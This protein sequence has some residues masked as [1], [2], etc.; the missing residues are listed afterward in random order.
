MK[1]ERKIG[2]LFTEEI[3]LTPPARFDFSATIYSH[4]WI[5]LPPFARL[6]G[7]AGFARIDALPS[8]AVVRLEVSAPAGYPSREIRVKAVS[9]RLLDAGDRE[10][11]AAM[12]ARV[13][14][15]DE[16]FSEF[17]AL[18]RRRGKPWN[19]F[20][21]GHGRL[22]RSPTVFEDLVKVI[23]TTN[24]QWRGTKRMVGELMEAFGTA[25]PHVRG[26]KLFPSPDAIASAS[27]EE[28]FARVRLGYR[29]PYIHAL[30]SEVTDGRLDLE[31]WLDVR[32]STG[33][34]KKRLR[35]IRGVGEYAAASM[36]M[37][38]GRYG[39]VPADSEFRKLMGEKYFPGE[40]FDLKKAL[41]VYRDWGHWQ[42][43][44][45]WLEMIH[46]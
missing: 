28:F 41:A 44:A 4:G 2:Q 18:C 45:Y 37:L 40:A 6:D 35:A 5:D 29:A 42:G 14:R 3:I 38:L 20:V 15:L 25:A 39:D 24:I 13:L 22:L 16:D 17:Y 10:R 1:K 32:V 21:R 23:C 33:E 36:L 34:L 7:R 31:S 46:S 11:I 30:A 9:D 12:V 19:Q 43:L 26:E 27:L 8:G